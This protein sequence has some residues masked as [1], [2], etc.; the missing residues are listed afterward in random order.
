MIDLPNLPDYNSINLNKIEVVANSNKVIYW[1]EDK[2]LDDYWMSFQRLHS[3][4]LSSLTTEDNAQLPE[5]IKNILDETIEQLKFTSEVKND[6]ERILIKLLIH[7]PEK[8]INISRSNEG[9][10]IIFFE[11]QGSYKNFLIDEDGD[12]ELLS[13]PNDKSKTHNKRFYKEDGINFT[14]VV[15]EFNEMR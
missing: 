9:E 12:I 1:R 2:T 5:K 10:F 4:F 11:S 8:K 15:R 13:I 3:P 7:N 14:K 6:I